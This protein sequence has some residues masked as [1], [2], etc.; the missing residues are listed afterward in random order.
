[1]N[2]YKKFFLSLNFIFLTIFVSNLGYSICA[3]SPSFISVKS[4]SYD[5]G[6]LDSTQVFVKPSL[7]SNPLSINFVFDNTDL[8][9]YDESYVS[10]QLIP[11]SEFQTGGMFVKTLDDGTERTTF[12]FTYNPGYK[13]VGS[14]NSKYNINGAVS[15]IVFREDSTKPSLSISGIDESTLVKSGENI[16]FNYL[17]SDGGSGLGKITITG[18][19]TFIYDYVADGVAG[20][21]SSY[22]DMPK[23]SRTYNIKL[24]DKLGNFELKTVNVNVDSK[25]PKIVEIKKIYDY[26]SSSRVSSV[27]F[28][29]LLEDE[30]FSSGL[31]PIISADISNINFDVKKISGVCNNFDLLEN[32]YIC[33]FPD[34]EITEITSTSRTTIFFNVTDGVGNS[35]EVSKTEEIFIDSSK[36][37]ISDFN[38][39]NSL[40][41]KNK[42]SIHD[43]N[44]TVKLVAKDKS[45]IEPRLI[46]EEFGEIQF[47]PSKECTF[48]SSSEILLCTWNLGNTID[49]FSGF[50]NL[51]STVF[52]VVVVDNYGNSAEEDVTIVFDSDSPVLT[53]E[54]EIRQK[55][56]ILIGVL[57]SKDSVDFRITLEDKNM[58]SESGEQFVF[59]DFSSVNFDD[60]YK[61]LEGKCYNVGSETVCDFLGIELNNGYY[62]KNV[63]FYVSDIMGNKNKFEFPLEVFAISDEVTESFDI[64][65][66]YILNPISRE[67]MLEAAVTT[68][69]EGTIETKE[70]GIEIINY[71][72]MGC[73][74]SSLENLSLIPGE[75]KLYPESIVYYFDESDKEFALKIRLRDHPFMID[76][77]ENEVSCT[78]SISKRN[79]ETVF[80]VELVDFNIII[81]FFNSQRGGITQALA[82]DI[83]SDINDADLLGEK[84]DE[85]YEV[86]SMLDSVCSTVSSATGIMS[87]VSSVWTLASIALHSTGYGTA[88]AYPVDGAVYSSDGLLSNLNTGVVGKFCDMITCRN[89]GLLTE[90]GLGFGGETGMG[91]WLDD[92]NSLTSE[93]C[94]SGFGKSEEDKK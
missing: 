29:V 17:V 57:Q 67:R 2:K 49:A 89:G 19:S 60:E 55:N 58:I 35:D 47:A 13:I 70:L 81:D 36:P 8:S 11:N 63:T 32:Q 41:I 43:K 18:G 1:M 76:L 90:A 38:V 54:I 74:E 40:G 16:S 80:P 4:G 37:V 33:E 45:L 83:V 10:F 46:V 71:Q 21:P 44:I 14:L 42:V 84:F 62:M 86:Y 88:V 73:N 22:S 15:S 27:K 91:E 48:D 39:Y 59:G 87:G 78:M 30:S 7:S 25:A 5:L 9:C 72:F 82:E 65:E 20:S 52:K 93:T 77:V 75:D 69:F 31:N 61:K 6:E 64:N 50:N 26:D 85:I 3:T 34:L 79:N 92:I 51:E 28:S 66:L 12:S 24:E 56:D 23:S 53:K 94:T 68:W